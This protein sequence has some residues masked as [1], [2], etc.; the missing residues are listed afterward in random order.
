[1]RKKKNLVISAA[2]RERANNK[3]SNSDGRTLEEIASMFDITRERVRQIEA[4]AL[5]SLR[6]KLAAKGIDNSLPDALEGNALN[7]LAMMETIRQYLSNTSGKDIPIF[8]QSGYRSPALN[9]AIGGAKNSDH[10]QAMAVDWIAPE[11]GTSLEIAQALAP[12]VND[13]G[14]GQLINEFPGAKGWVHTSIKKPT[15]AANQV[16]TITAQGTVSGVTA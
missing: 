6:Q 12:Y 10:M 1:M 15:L 9:A 5:R 4:K 2:V 13:L 14:I 8:I 16:I 3:S 7:T 11:F